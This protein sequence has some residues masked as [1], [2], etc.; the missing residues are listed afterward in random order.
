MEDLALGLD[1]ADRDRPPQLI[2][3][4][5]VWS[6]PASENGTLVQRRRWEGG[7]LATSLKRAPASLVRS[8]ARADF[9]GV[10]AALDLSVPP[11]ALLFVLNV[12][13]V[14]LGLVFAAVG[15]PIWPLILQVATVLAAFAALML[16]WM[17]EGTRFRFRSDAAPPANLRSL[18]VAHLSSFRS[19]RRTQRMAAVG[20]VATRNTDMLRRS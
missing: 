8:I 4:A 2:E 20:S 16:A 10:A 9:V 6:L 17:R 1:L 5:T 7:Y 3:K 19:C 14:I 13:A 12:L 15:G 11:L 18:E